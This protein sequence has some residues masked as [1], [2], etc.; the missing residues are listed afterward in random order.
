MNECLTLVHLTTNWI[1][2]WFARDPPPVAGKT[3]EK[4]T[5]ALRLVGIDRISESGLLLA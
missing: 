5:F 4:P 2:K 1:T 3:A